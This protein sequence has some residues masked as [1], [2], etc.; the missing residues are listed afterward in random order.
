[1][2]DLDLIRID[3]GT[4]ARVEIN[5]EVVAEYAE[6]YRA[7]SEFPPVTVFFDGTDRWL[8]DGFHRYFAAKQAGKKSILEKVIPGT[9]RDAKLHSFGANGTHGQRPTTADK[10]K[11]IEAMLADAEWVLWSDSKIAKACHVSDKTVTARRAAIFGNSED[12]PTVRKVERN[13]KT[14]EQDTA[15]IGK[16]KAAGPSATP[17]AQQPE[18][19]AIKKP[20]PKKEVEDEHYFGPSDEEIEAARAAAEADLSSLMKLIEADDKLA[21]AAEE[22]KRLRAELAAV[23][24]ARDGYMNRCNEMLTRIKTLKRQLEKAKEAAHA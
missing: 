11:A 2:L 14:Y 15:K 1:M 18:A 20:A 24:S 4:Q 10:R 5:Q 19:A 6:A 3:G 7:G 8:A 16:S 12:A 13:G 9:L 21:A 23:T 17:P 22:I